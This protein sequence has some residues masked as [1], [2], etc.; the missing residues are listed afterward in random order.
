MRFWRFFYINEVKFSDNR[1]QDLV[2]ASK[3]KEQSSSFF[4]R[5]AHISTLCGADCDIC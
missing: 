1:K 2:I 3:L 4:T 5:L